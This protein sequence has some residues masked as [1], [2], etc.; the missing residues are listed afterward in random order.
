MSFMKL[1]KFFLT[2]STFLVVGSLV[3]LFYPGPRLSLEFTGGTL[4]NVTIPEGKTKADFVKALAEYKNASG[5]T[6]GTTVVTTTKDGTAMLRIRD[7]TNDEHLS[8]LSTLKT[9]LGDLQ[10]RQFTTIGPTVGG[11]LKTQS[12]WALVIASL[13]IIAYIAFAF[14]KVPSKLSAWRFGFFAL[15]AMIHDLIVTTGIF[16]TLGLLITHTQ[17]FSV[18][19]LVSPPEIDTLFIVALLT[20]LG[21]SVND[22]IIIFDRIRENI[23]FTDKNE[24]FATTVERSFRETIIRTVN[25]STTTLITLFCLAIFGAESIRWFVITLIIGICLGNYSSYFVATPLLIFFQKK[26]R[27]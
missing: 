2:L 9:R 19:G 21:Y 7:I 5:A 14:R 20:I 18:F 11:T 17:I 13:G 16:I 26:E 15:I 25:T 23:A 27:N 4:M 1:S 10:E 6:L 3:L 22:T 8:L 24:A 12:L